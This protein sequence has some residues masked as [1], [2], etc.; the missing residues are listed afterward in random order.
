M[1][2][3]RQLN[4]WSYS[5]EGKWLADPAKQ[6]NLQW[7]YAI[8]SVTSSRLLLNIRSTAEG[9]DIPSD[10][11]PPSSILREDYTDY[12]LLKKLPRSRTKTPQDLT[13]RRYLT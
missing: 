9:P 12:K 1:F 10:I 4:Y 7:S 6:L 13:L 3:H 11:T 5:S 8:F 2:S